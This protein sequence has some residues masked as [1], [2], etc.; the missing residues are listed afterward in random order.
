MKQYDSYKDSGVKWI[1]EIP[2][3]WEICRLKN[4]TIIVLGKMLMS[5]PPKGEEHYYTLER[6][7]K[8][9]NIGWLEVYDSEDEVEEMWFN[10]SEKAMYCLKPN[11]I[12]MNEGGDV[13]KI[14][15][16]KNNG[17]NCYIQNSVNK[18]T[19]DK[20]TSPFY[21]EYL[22]FAIA[23]TNY[24]WSIV[25]PVSIAHLTKEKLSGTPIVLPPIVEQQAIATYLDQ[26]CAEI[27]KAIATQQKR[28]ELLQ[29]LRQN[30]ITH[31]VTRGINPDVPLKDSGV[32]WIGMVPEHWGKCR[33]KDFVTLK[34]DVSLSDNKIG[35][36]NIEGKTGQYIETNSEFEGNGVAFDINDIIYGKLRPYLQ[37]VWLA[38]FAGNA[39]GDFFVFRC[40]RNCESKYLQYLM[41]SDGF[42][43]E[44][45]GATLGAKMPRVSS[46]FILS[47][48][49]YLPSI[50]EQQAIV[51]HIISETTKLD[52]LVA[53]ANRQ[54]SLLQELKQS[55]I[56]EVVTG[57][58]KVC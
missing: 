23:K 9:K 20:G 25:N 17:Y 6:Y 48:P 56:T 41:L 12:V 7:L 2:S 24:F 22:L 57:K 28:I 38:T 3:H 58:R 54:I 30:I 42:T 46:D 15:I 35:L 40:K 49:Y 31:A 26:K 11:D 45:N 8:S 10:D 14:G 19:V 21:L 36:E 18:I 27:D 29:E 44:C 34:T 53:K 1:G 51:A 52:K 33:F 37:K 55:I 5:S 4:H 32:E 47:L 39:V 43:S 50:S 13:G 16:W